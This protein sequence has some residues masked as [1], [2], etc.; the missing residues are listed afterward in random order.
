[1]QSEIWKPVCDYKG[2]YEVSSFGRVKSVERYVKHRESVKFVRERILK[3]PPDKD[4]YESVGLCRNGMMVTKRVHRLVAEAFISNPENKPCTNHIDGVK[5]NN[6]VHNLEWNTVCENNNHA[7]RTGLKN[8]NHS[9][10]PVGMVVDG[11]VVVI[12]ESATFAANALSLYQQHISRVCLGEL[13]THGGYGW[14]FC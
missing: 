6:Y 12:F 4:G 11:E 7:Y 3:K 8:N 13:K 9:K 10:K 2:I 14:T 5:T 1:M